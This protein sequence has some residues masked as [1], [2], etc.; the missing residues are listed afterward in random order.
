MNIFLQPSIS[1]I[2]QDDPHQTVNLASHP[3]KH[4][5]YKIAGRELP[6]IINRLDALMLVLKRCSGDQCR[7]PWGQ[8]HPKGLVKSLADALDEGFDDF[9]EKQ[10]KV[11]FSS[12]EIYYT[13]EAEGPQQFDVYGGSQKRWSDFW[14]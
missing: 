9:Y 13:I 2:S 7:D 11:S 5:N 6:Q 1:N 14:A 4:A 10:P 8:L 12:C 3:N